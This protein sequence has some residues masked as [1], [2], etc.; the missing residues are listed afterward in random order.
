MECFDDVLAG[1]CGSNLGHEV[2]DESHLTV[3]GKSRLGPDGRQEC[4]VPGSLRN[5][6][7][8]YIYIEYRQGFFLLPSA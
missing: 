5:R 7:P 1:I 4:T 8:L 3:T 2:G 6:V